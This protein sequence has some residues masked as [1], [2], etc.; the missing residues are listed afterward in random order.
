MS[1][2]ASIKRALP[3]FV[4]LVGLALA[5]PAI[6]ADFTADD[7]LHRVVQRDDPGMPGL[8]SHRWDLFSFVTGDHDDA[9]R[10]RDAGLYSWWTDPE[11]KLAFWRPITS[12]THALD[13]ALWPDSAAAQLAHNLVWLAIVL[14]LVWGFYRRFIAT[15][16]GSVTTPL[17]MSS[18]RCLRLPL[19]P[20]RLSTS[21]MIWN[22][23]PTA[24]KNSPTAATCS[25]VPPPATAPMRARQP[26]GAAVLS[27]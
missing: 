18:P 13:H 12:A 3:W 15:A 17:A 26:A 9:V 6:T 27:R 20:R 11:L 14:V 22:A 2:S 16:I 8:H 10:L 24:S 1:S 5:A 4:I 25:S 23:S 19:K 7:H 21:S